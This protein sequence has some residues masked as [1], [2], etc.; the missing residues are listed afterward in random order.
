MEKLHEVHA[1][2]YKYRD[3][4]AVLQRNE[5]FGEWCVVNVT[6]KQAKLLAKALSKLV[7]KCTPS[8]YKIGK[9]MKE[10]NN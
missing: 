1:F 6:F 2:R 5:L 3:R 9:V 10:D 7:T 8:G 4:I